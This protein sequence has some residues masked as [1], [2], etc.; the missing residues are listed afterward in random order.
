MNIPNS[1]E[2]ICKAELPEIGAVAYQLHHR[3]TQA[4]FLL[5]ETEDDN[6][7]FSVTFKTTPENSEGTPHILEHSVLCGSELFPVKDP[8]MELAKGSLNTFL[9]AFTYPD[10]TSYPVASQNEADF[11]NLMAVYMDAVF[12]PNI[13]KTDK[14]LRQEGWHYEMEDTESPLKLNGVVY[15]EMRGAYS[16]PMSV[17]DTVAMERLYPGTTYAYDSGG[18]PKD[19]PGLTQEKFLAFH[20]RFYHPSNGWFYLY[21]NMDFEERLNWL[22]E[23]YLSRY[24]AIDPKTDVPLAPHSGEVLRAVCPYS[25]PE[26]DS[27][28]KCYFQK[29]IRV[30]GLFDPVESLAYQILAFALLNAPGAPVRQALLDEGICAN[31]SG[32]HASWFREPNFSIVAQD[33]EKDAFERFDEVLTRALS[34]QAEHGINKRA[35]LAG[36]TNIEFTMREAD[37]GSFPRGLAYWNILSDAW[38]HDENEALG[39]LHFDP[40]FVKLRE[41]VQGDYFEKLLRDKI[42]NNTD[43]VLIALEP[44]EGLTEK[45]DRALAK[46]LADY[47]ASLSEEEIRKIVRETAE[48]RAYQE[49]PS[50]PEELESVPLLDLSEIDPEPRAVHNEEREIAGVRTIY[51]EAVTSGIGYLDAFF[52]LEGLRG[53]DLVVAGLLKNLYTQM[54]TEHFNYN[55]LTNEIGLF[56]GGIGASTNLL[57]KLDS[58]EILEHFVLS[59][60]YLGKDTRD[61]VRLLTEVFGHTRFEDTV[62]IREILSE[63]RVNMKDTLENS[64][65]D[66]AMQRAL[67]Y[68]SPVACE[69][70][71]LSGLEFYRYVD[72]LLK[73]FD[74]EKDALVRKLYAV[75]RE[76]LKKGNLTLSFT[77]GQ[78]EWEAIREALPAYLET[79]QDGASERAPRTF[80]KALLNEGFK[81]A[82]LVQYVA[83]G[84]NI[85]DAG[86]RKFPEGVMNVF[87]QIM[88]TEYLWINLRVKGGA[89]GCMVRFDT[90]GRLVFCSFRDPHLKE[91]LDIYKGVPEYLKTLEI[92]DR[93]LRKY[94][95]GT[96]G[97]VDSPLLPARQGRA[98][99]LLWLAGATVE[100]RRENRRQ[101]RECTVEDL[102]ALS[103][104]IEGALTT[105]GICVVGS[106]QKIREN[107]ELF[108]SISGFTGE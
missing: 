91:S 12:R 101:M 59:A 89:Y 17:L 70:E 56:T 42:L 99:M 38:L 79:L 24:E 52:S 75:E 68:T 2:L 48:L 13:Y 34:E 7:V 41:L 53:E 73:N 88:G 3:K 100:R 15:N 62:R 71:R 97:M 104:L 76:I 11:R 92:S 80:Q 36:I 40:L 31:V 95:I 23:A 105:G 86:F 49:T 102:R 14:I 28:A 50:T 94:I 66:T 27:E 6:K 39:L 26:G 58:E 33:A 84:G 18:D 81:T 45:E 98:D 1:Y 83:W 20:R 32:Y 72:R 78:E 90:D 37:Y 29:A 44:E 5:L 87:R 54:S 96:F 25:V 21:G 65:H 43:A 8:F 51:H 9:N 10:R 103:P 16:D 64:G 30:G 46:K 108:G 69:N 61:A 77:G 106:E 57:T 67:S 19:I 47:K 55:D 82:S 35:L 60:R 85:H 22:D 63:I 4:K 107:A 93:D 74:A